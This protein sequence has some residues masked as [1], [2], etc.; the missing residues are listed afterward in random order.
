MS[1]EFAVKLIEY[2]KYQESGELD[3]SMEELTSENLESIIPLLAE[4][5]SLNSLR[6][7][8][9][10]IARLPE[11][12]GLL[13]Q[14]TSLD[15]TQNRLSE[16]PDSIGNLRVLNT[17]RL[18]D[19]QLTRLPMGLSEL[20]Q[21]STL[22]L[23]KNQ[24]RNLPSFLGEMDFERKTLEF[25]ENPLSEFPPEV[26]RQGKNGVLAFLRA[27]AQEST[28]KWIS[29]LIVVG[30]GG[31]GKTQLIRSVL[32]EQFEKDSS[33]TFGIEIR[34]VSFQH[35]EDRDEEIL[36]K[37]WDFGGQAIYHATHQFFL[38]NRSLF[39]V[40]WNP[41]MGYEQCKLFY[42]LD[43]IR[44]LAPNSP[45]MIVATHVDERMA[46]LPYEQIKRNYPQVV[47]EWSVSN[48]K[49]RAASGI[50]QLRDDIIDHAMQ[51][52]LMGERW[53]TSWLA[54]A[55][56]IRETAKSTRRISREELWGIMD[57][58]EN[59][60]ANPSPV[61][62]NNR[63]ILANWLHDLG[64]ILFFQDDEEL[65][66]TV[67]LDPHWVTKKI[68]D[69][70]VSEQVEQGHAILTLDA[71]N[72][73]W[74]DDEIDEAMSNKL[75]R[76]MENFDL[77]YRIPDDLQ[78]RSLI[79]E[80]LSEDPPLYEEVWKRHGDMPSCKQ[81]SMRF[82][83]RQK[84]PAGIPTWFIAR[85]HRFTLGL[86][87]LHGALFGDNRRNPRHLGLV[88]APAGGEYI[89]IT[90]RGPNPHS[91]FELLRDGLEVTLARF[92][93]LKNQIVRT[94]PCPDPSKTGCRSRFRLAD[95]EKR[96]ELD[97]PKSTVEC[98]SCIRDVSV[99]ELLF[100]ISQTTEQLVLEKMNKMESEILTSDAKTRDLIVAE[101]REL[102]SLS[103]RQFLTLFNSQQ[104]LPESQTPRVFT[105]RTRESG[106]WKK[107][108]N[109]YE[110]KW[111]L[112]LYCE[113]PGCWHP[114]DNEL[115]IYKIRDNKSFFKKIG[116]WTK[117]LVTVLKYAAPLV[118]PS[119]THG[120]E[121]INEL[122]KTDIRLMG[123]LVK[124]LPEVTIGNDL[125]R[126]STNEFR[127]RIPNEHQSESLSELR[128]L[129]L[130]LDPD[131]EFGRMGGLTKTLTPEGHYL[132][133]CDHH[134]KEVMS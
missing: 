50:S 17:L 80:K 102:R 18:G 52:P 25:S 131:L 110:N 60:A 61:S 1:L 39:I 46:E 124:K 12:I 73:I 125:M 57:D 34:P 49:R 86:H 117:R 65:G 11:S 99:T 30:E 70:L 43:T 63:G 81:I 37:A 105:L 130:T 118:G 5:D 44:S 51:L 84:K 9:N 4:H 41:R 104:R 123:E 29:K 36:L 82:D 92:E 2:A 21:L 78:N 58:R 96:L 107:L 19:N 40:V 56:R 121:E 88:R 31:V 27:N 98:Q 120:Y 77:S 68:S 97:P 103:Q 94:I 28:R 87:W 23:R 54:A 89:F 35:P 62:K 85:S 67:I 129:L 74:D 127:H 109:I 45:V 26:L 3:L 108:S 53:P 38:S 128:K 22:D 132:W 113:F 114:P 55:N 32:G 115:G 7:R 69:I 75:L 33:T 76:L 16:V 13:T 111:N 100:G 101:M 122:I 15:L 91:F 10:R 48:K 14:L 95:L 126:I 24:F 133:L 47:G 134:R 106:G 8:K 79:V 6:L 112:Q 59:F 71:M 72:L 119:I 93:G 42:W 116:L 66:D 64:D 90:V 83:L 20:T